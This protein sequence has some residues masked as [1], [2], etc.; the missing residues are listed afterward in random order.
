MDKASSVID[1]LRKHITAP[2]LAFAIVFYCAVHV[3]Y[4]LFIAVVADFNSLIGLNENDYLLLSAICAVA[5]QVV[6][7]YVLLDFLGALLVF[8]PK[9]YRNFFDAAQEEFHRASVFKNLILIKI[10]FSEYGAF[11]YKRHIRTEL[12]RGISNDVFI[13]DCIATIIVIIFI[14][15]MLINIKINKE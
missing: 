14:A 13:I 3:N 6:F 2:L 12:F 8:G 10:I 7:L 11:V 15:A 9:K 4:E 1:F 5:A